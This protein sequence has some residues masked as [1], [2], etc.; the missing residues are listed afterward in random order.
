MRKYISKVTR[1]CENINSGKGNSEK[2]YFIE[3][4]PDY[5]AHYMSEVGN[6][7][8]GEYNRNIS[9]AEKEEKI[10]GD[11]IDLIEKLS[12]KKLS[13]IVSKEIFA[14][15]PDVKSIAFAVI[16]HVINSVS[17]QTILKEMSS[18]IDMRHLGFG[19]SASFDLLPNE[20]P[21]ISEAG[22]GSRNGAR[23]KQFATTV[24]LEAINH[25]IT[26]QASYYEV[27]CGNASLGDFVKKAILALQ[28]AMSIESY[29]ALRTGLTDPRVSSS[30]R[31]TGFKEETLIQLCDLITAKNRS[32]ATLLGTTG[33]LAKI[34]P[35][36]TDGFRITTPSKDMVFDVVGKFYR[37]NVIQ[38]PQILNANGDG[39]ALKDNEIY[40]ISTGSEKLVRGV[41]EG[42]MLSNSNSPYDNADNSIDTTIN[43]RFAF[44]NISN[45][46]G[47]ILT[48]Q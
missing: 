37:W 28:S 14:N 26:L 15:L 5:F 23:Q 40:V 34:R 10:H 20:L 35:S 16:D 18:F 17:P 41:M 13:T 29:N 8:I 1:M 32:N 45:A 44:K 30:L 47:G 31:I 27:L 25:D 19:D 22:N 3:N 36:A 2:N 43:A 33:A 24:T 39:L 9:F 46:T 21:I 4:F 48:L 38:I 42:N 7:N 12:G 6:E 11:F